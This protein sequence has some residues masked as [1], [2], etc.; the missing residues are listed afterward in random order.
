MDRCP[1]VEVVDLQERV[2]FWLGCRLVALSEVVKDLDQTAPVDGT[3]EP[4]D[5]EGL[6]AS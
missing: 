4:G 1:Q 3:S 5:K 6:N 2:P